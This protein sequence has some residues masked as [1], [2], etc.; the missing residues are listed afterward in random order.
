[1]QARVRPQIARWSLAALL[2]G[3]VAPALAVAQERPRAAEPLQG[4]VERRNG[5]A[6]GIVR[7]VPW[8][9]QPVAVNVA[10]GRTTAMTFPAPIA[11]IITTATREMLTIETVG[12]RL[13]ISPL[14]SDYYGELFV[15]L[16]NDEQVPVIATSTELHQADLAVRVVSGQ[17][18]G[19]QGGGGEG[20]PPLPYWTPLRLM[21]AMILGVQEPGVTVAQHPQP[22]EAYNDSVLRLRATATWKT[23][24]Y[25]GVI[26]EAEN[27]TT[28]WLRL[29]LESLHFPGL[30]AVHAERD[31][32]APRPTNPAQALIAHQKSRVYLVRM[33][34]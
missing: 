6:H 18:S 26:L 16:T 34:E 20:R 8:T 27:L 21:R 13:F 30:L 28:Q 11:S 9:G 4:L 31:T 32:L 1:M 19:G 17:T 24:R 23:P 7:L 10:M 25:E 3:F 29:A 5:A 12:A 15:V 2:G 22:I 33:P 14:T